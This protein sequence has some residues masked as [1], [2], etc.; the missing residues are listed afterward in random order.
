V[1]THSQKLAKLVEKFSGEAPI[2]L[3]LTGGETRVQ[4]QRMVEESE[5]E[6][7]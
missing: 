4:G 2:S 6:A 3:E 7:G 5:E 1:V